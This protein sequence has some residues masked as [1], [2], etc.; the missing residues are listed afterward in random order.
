MTTV[1]RTTTGNGSIKHTRN[2]ESAERKWASVKNTST[3]AV[4]NWAY[5]SIHPKYKTAKPMLR[6][7][8]HSVAAQEGIAVA[9]NAPID[10]AAAAHASSRRR[11]STPPTRFARTAKAPYAPILAKD[12][13]PASTSAP[14]SDGASVNCKL[15]TVENDTTRHRPRHQPHHPA[16]PSPT[17]SPFSMQRPSFASRKPARPS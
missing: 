12:G 11:P 10:I 7:T 13:T 14:A 17:R 4:S 8:A 15:T 2:V 9:P 5:S 1:A 3:W 16:K 6:T